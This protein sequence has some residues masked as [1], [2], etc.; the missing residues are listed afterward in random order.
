MN[1]QTNADQIAAWNDQVGKTW[2]KMNE[3]LDR[4]LEPIGKAMLARAE[5]AAGQSVLDIGC[6][7]GATSI[8]AAR[9]VGDGGKVLGVDVSTPLLDLA[10]KH[11]AGL[12]NIDFLAGDAQTTPFAAESFERVISRFGVMFFDDPT[13]AFAN[14]RRGCRPDALLCFACWREGKDNPWLTMPMQAAG[15]LVDPLPPPEPGAPGPT[16]FADPERVRSILAGSGWRDIEVE[17]LDVPVGG[18]DL[19]ATTALM[20]RVGPVGHAIRNAGAGREL[21]TAV[22]DAVREVVRGFIKQDGL[23]WMPSASWLVTAR[24]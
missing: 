22:E 23:A 14:I 7:A 15:H 12:S 9:V 1:E 4:Q 8:D 18:G 17:P 6:G 3:G 13:A 10:R 19:E 24:A 11:A 2:V 21:I 5:L 20:T 16:A